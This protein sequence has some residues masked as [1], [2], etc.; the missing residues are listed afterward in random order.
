MKQ[1][2]LFPEIE[3][4]D[5]SRHDYNAGKGDV[6]AQIFY[7]IRTHS[8]RTTLRSL[9]KSYES[10]PHAKWFLDNTKALEPLEAKK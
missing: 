9:A 6:I 3:P 7:H 8:V 4:I 5:T 1:T 10:N 2:P